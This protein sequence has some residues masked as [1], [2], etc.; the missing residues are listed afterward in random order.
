MC[1]LKALM[2]FISI[3]PFI[4]IHLHFDLPI[5][6]LRDFMMIVQTNP[7]VVGFPF[8]GNN[9]QRGIPQECGGNL[10]TRTILSGMFFNFTKPF[11]DGGVS[12]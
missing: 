11:R 6:F 1:Q 8:F 3:N 12:V 9:G 4:K 2:C 5:V 7:S 10:F